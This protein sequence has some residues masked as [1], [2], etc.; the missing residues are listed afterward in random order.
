[1]RSRVFCVLLGLAMGWTVTGAPADALHLHNDGRAPDRAGPPYTT[2][3]IVALQKGSG[4]CPEVPGWAGESLKDLLKARVAIYRRDHVQVPG[5]AA[6]E[7]ERN[8]RSAKLDHL[9]RKYDLDRFCVYTAKA[10]RLRFP[11]PQ[12]VG[13]E[14]ADPD[15]MALIPTAP[16]E[17]GA[18]GDQTWPILA[19]HFIEQVGKVRLAPASTPSVRIV[20]VDTQRTGEGPPDPPV[21]STSPAHYPSWHGHGM[22]NLGNEMVCGH[23]AAWQSC[24]IHVATRLA[25]HYDDY[26]PDMSFSPNPAPGN[27]QAGHLGL[28]GDLGLAILQEI[29]NWQEHYPNTK[30]ILNLSVGWDGEL[31]G[32]DLTAR[33]PAELEASSQEVYGALRIAADLG[34]LVIASAGNRTGGEKSKWP[35]LPAAWELRPPSW[36]PFHLCKVVYAVGGVDWQGLPLPNARR[37][38]EPWRVAYGDHAVTR[39]RAPG[40]G[41]ANG[42]EGSTKIYTGTSVSTAVVSSIAAVAWYLR[43]DL[44]PAQVMKRVSRASEIL[45]S[46]AD[47]YAWKRFKWI[48]APHL[49]RLSLCQTVLSLCGPDEKRCHRKLEACDCRRSEHKPADLMAILPQEPTVVPFKLIEPHP[50]CATV[51]KGPGAPIPDI[52]GC[53]M[54]ML[55]DMTAPSSV[56]TQPPENPCPACTAVPDKPATTALLL[57]ALAPNANLLEGEAS[58][59]GPLSYDLAAGLD[60]KWVEEAASNH[61]TI[62]SAIL[63]IHCQAKVPAEERLE[64]TDQMRLLFNEPQPASMR[65]SLGDLSPWTSLAGCTA[66]VDFTLQVTDSSDQPERSVQS[67]VYVD[68]EFP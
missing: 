13:L 40:V 66:S 64:V 20:F 42:A 63:V 31:Q 60:P 17:L 23:D 68:P 59:T 2:G 58:E 57:T 54:E 53:P 52:E 65:I 35:L 50:P 27:E 8:E 4:V 29:Y 62:E 22:A 49:R 67:P 19:D 25:L 12:R 9:L 24:A 16:A 26:E 37:G 41:V 47:F 11:P 51:F 39:T 18:I 6:A 21:P 5:P 28:V 3:R 32:S 38:G 7:K 46:P 55:P 15:R 45:P 34:V 44:N 1:M 33:K 48:E 43:P 61:T 10:P 36:L 30:L 14:R 56:A